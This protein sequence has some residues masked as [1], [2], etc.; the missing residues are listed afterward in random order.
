MSQV[1]TAL[2]KGIKMI[3]TEVGAD[4]HEYSSYTKSTV[5]E[6]NSFLA[7]CA[8][9]GVGNT[10]WMNEN[11]NN[12]PRYQT[13]G[14][15]MPTGSG[16][17][18]NPPSPPPTP[19]PTPPPAPSLFSDG[20]ES[21]N[22][23][24]WSSITKTSGETVTLASSIPHHGSYHAVF[25]TTGSYLSRENAFLRKNINMEEVFA[26]GYFRIVGSVTG[27][28]ILGD[29][30]DRF[31]LLRFISGSEEVAFAGIRRDNGVNKWVL[32]TDGAEMSSAVP[33]SP[34][35]WYNVELHWNAAE[36]TAELFINGT[37][38]LETTAGGS[39][40]SD[41]TSVDMGIISTYSV[42]NR[43]QVYGDCFSVSNSFIASE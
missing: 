28:R 5:A 40:N 12:W 26:N 21:N 22:F 6:L 38:I 42:Q 29:N 10:V 35:H 11:L 16:S 3:N 31:Y 20:F 41:V 36:R 43:L 23:N 9:L 7:Q 4:Y 17:P 37:K 33:I 19:P 15:D 18:E 13:L 24:S 25:A 8:D 1:N 34:D 39:S 27:S 14:L 30:G 2:G 32:Y